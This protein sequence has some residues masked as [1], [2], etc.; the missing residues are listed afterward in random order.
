[1]KEYKRLTSKGKNGLWGIDGKLVNQRQASEK[2]FAEAFD[3]I[4]NRLAELEDKIENGTFIELPC[5]VGDKIFII[6][7]S[8]GK[9]FLCNDYEEDEYVVTNIYMDKRK[10]IK[11]GVT[12][13]FVRL[14]PGDF[15]QTVFLTKAEAEAKLKE[16]QNE[17]KI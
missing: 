6:E 8:G 12:N 3:I 15:G 4:I 13:L 2:V 14:E 16:Q 17:G 7:Q 11:I 1:L 5:K 10:N 9:W